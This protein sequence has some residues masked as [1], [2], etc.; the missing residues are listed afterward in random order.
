MPQGERV[1]A[2]GLASS[3]VNRATAST[4]RLALAL[5]LSSPSACSSE[6]VSST[7]GAPTPRLPSTIASN[8]AAT[9]CGPAQVEELRRLLVGGCM[10]ASLVDVRPLA[11]AT[12]TEH[13][14]LGEG[15]AIE[16]TPT[17]VVGM[18]P[19]DEPAFRKRV[20]AHV[21]GVRAMR[22]RNGDA[23]EPSF[24]LSIHREV[25]LRTVDVVLRALAAEQVE[26]GFL[27]FASG[28]LPRTAMPRHPE[29]YAR[30]RESIE[31]VADSSGRAT[32]VARAIEPFAEQCAPLGRAFAV[33]AALPAEQRCET[34]MGAAAQAIVECGCP[35]YEPA[36][37]SWLQA[38]V[39]PADTA[40][41]HANRVTLRPD[42]AERAEP[43][44]TWASFVE[45]HHAPM[46]SLWLELAH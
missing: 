14:E 21:D 4:A 16:L 23:F 20:R 28:T 30:V 15:F 12:W 34:M 37:V 35:A 42:V 27:T 11:I 36:L 19:W 22:E 45:R 10:E 6:S 26:A 25:E 13:E 40:H 43:E 38:L 41:L 3:A 8:P 31:S 9:A 7:G 2:Q 24:V 44:T 29:A 33:G 32:F 39:G 17:A 18:G 46:R 1:P 5:V